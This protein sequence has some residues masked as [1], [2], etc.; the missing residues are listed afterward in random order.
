MALQG[1]CY[2]QEH[3]LLPLL[4]SC[5]F[6]VAISWS[7]GFHPHRHPR[8]SLNPKGDMLAPTLLKSLLTFHKLEGCGFSFS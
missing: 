5:N 2:G 6:L 1:R 4:L 7:V 8:V 3:V